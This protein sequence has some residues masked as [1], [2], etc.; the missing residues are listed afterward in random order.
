MARIADPA[1]TQTNYLR[2]ISSLRHAMLHVGPLLLIIPWAS[3]PQMHNVVVSQ[4]HREIILLDC[5]MGPQGRLAPSHNVST[6]RKSC[7]CLAD[8]LIRRIGRRARVQRPGRLS[9]GD[10]QG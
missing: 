6:Y 7:A 3:R 9:T 1:R 4:L 10:V 8:D 2:N 5:R